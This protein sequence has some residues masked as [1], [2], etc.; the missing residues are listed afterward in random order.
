MSR[1]LTEGTQIVVGALG[2]RVYSTEGEDLHFVVA[3]MLISRGLTIAA[4]ESCTGGLIGHLL[5]QVPGISAS[6]DRVVVAYSNRAK[7][8]SLGVPG[9]LIEKHGA[10]SPEVAEAM[11]RGV[12][13]EAGTDIGI[14]TTG[15]AGPGGGGREKPVGL[16]YFGL[17]GEE[18]SQA[19][20]MV[21]ERTREIIKLKAAVYALDLVRVYMLGQGG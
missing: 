21:F 13:R 15:I 1:V 12:R 8:D 14:S 6:L 17:A 5:T 9:G 19:R 4:A 16:V 7:V 20:R 2:D 3:K 11:A 10:V 18:G